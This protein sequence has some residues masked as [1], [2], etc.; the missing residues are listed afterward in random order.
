MQPVILQ[1]HF[2]SG[3][4]DATRALIRFRDSNDKGFLKNKQAPKKLW[5]QFIKEHNLEGMV[6]PLQAAKKWDN[7]KQRYKELKT[8]KTGSGTDGGEETAASWVYFEDMHAVLGGRP[9]IDPPLLVASA[10]SEEDP[11]TLLLDMVEGP[12]SSASASTS[13]ASASAA[14]ASAASTSAASASAASS[15]AS[16]QSTSA[17][18]SEESP[19]TPSPRKKKRKSNPTLDFLKAESEREQRRHEESEA[20]TDRF[21]DLFERMVDKM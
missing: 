21:L 2:T 5:E 4:T 13:A 15:S 18:R 6:T 11:T 17:T 16:V 12:S 10:S 1:M 9:S 3:T 7:L 14:S 19:P 20:K 8:P